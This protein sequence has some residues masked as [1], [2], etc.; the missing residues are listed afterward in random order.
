MSVPLKRRISVFDF[1]LR[2]FSS[3]RS[4]LEQSLGIQKMW[5]FSRK[6]DGS[7]NYQAWQAGFLLKMG[8]PRLNLV[9]LC[10]RLIFSVKDGSVRVSQFPPKDGTGRR[11]SPFQVHAKYSLRLPLESRKSV[12]P[13]H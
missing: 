10:T 6:L 7:Q 11:T 8:A 3:W 9:G 5:C 4:H 1:T 2:G 13:P 12:R